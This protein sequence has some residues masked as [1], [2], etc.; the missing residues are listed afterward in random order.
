MELLEQIERYLARSGTRASMFGRQVVGDPRFVQDLRKGRR[1]RRKTA[2]RILNFLAST[3]GVASA[4]SDRL[5]R[6]TP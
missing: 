4:R 1:P 6:P 3:E 5:D 2:Q